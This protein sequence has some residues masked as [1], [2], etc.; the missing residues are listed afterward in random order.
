MTG[1]GA[2][3]DRGWGDS[4]DS[5]GKYTTISHTEVRPTQVQLLIARTEV[6]VAPRQ[7]SAVQ[8]QSTEELDGDNATA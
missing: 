8:R 5:P 2:K 6:L 4:N 7:E 3:G 1:G